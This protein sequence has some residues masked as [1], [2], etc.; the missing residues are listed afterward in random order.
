MLG[1][2]DRAGV[3]SKARCSPIVLPILIAFDD[4]NQIFRVVKS[5][6][7]NF[8]RVEKTAVWRHNSYV[9]AG[10]KRKQVYEEK[11]VTKKALGPPPGIYK[12][13]MKKRPA[14]PKPR[15]ELK[16][17]D[18]ATTG[19]FP[20]SGV[21]LNPGNNYTV[22]Q[23]ITLVPQ[24]TDRDERIGREIFIS[25]LHFKSFAYYQGNGTGTNVNARFRC[26]IFVDKEAQTLGTDAAE[27]LYKTRTAGNID[28]NTTRFL[29]DDPS[30][31]KVLYNQLSHEMV[32]ANENLAM[33]SFHQWETV[34]PV[35]L[36]VKFA[37]GV[38]VPV[39]NALYVLW[40]SDLDPSAI[41]VPE[42]YF[43]SRLMFADQ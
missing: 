37:S 10:G 42:F 21:Q 38:N 9:M 32:P 3:P 16:F 40:I 25:S 14:I 36:S 18:A 2:K 7:V 34:L 22:A 19:A 33:P 8:G 12:K 17:H 35:N 39:T 28:M 24:G 29:S 11:T 27:L 1:Y 26:V 30:R 31:F 43:Q 20:G 15:K 13:K 6:V 5:S 4:P 41:F 23:A